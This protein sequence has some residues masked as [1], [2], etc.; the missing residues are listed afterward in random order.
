MFLFLLILVVLLICAWMWT[1]K[2]NTELQWVQLSFL[3]YQ[4]RT[5]QTGLLW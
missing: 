1:E 2:R 4:F 3:P 5:Y